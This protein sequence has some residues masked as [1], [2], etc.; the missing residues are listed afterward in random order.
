MDI[1]NLL[2]SLKNEVELSADE[3]VMIEH[4]INDTALLTSRMIA[5]EDVDLELALVKA[6]ALNIAE[7][8]RVK[9]QSALNDFIMQLVGKAMTAVFA[10]M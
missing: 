2:E 6:T 7:A 5:G 8:K 10:A 1:T 4:V 9:V 3:Q